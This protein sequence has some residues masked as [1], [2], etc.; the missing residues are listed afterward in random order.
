M[1]YV[2]IR[3]GPGAAGALQTNAGEMESSDPGRGAVD[4]I[5]P[6]AYQVILDLYGNHPIG[7]I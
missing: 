7:S 6:L 5:H 3:K 1:E 2:M 4:P